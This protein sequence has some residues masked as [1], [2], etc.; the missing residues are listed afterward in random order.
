M[1]RL[2]VWSVAIATAY[3]ISACGQSG[4]LYL[5]GNPSEIQTPAAEPDEEEEK[6]TADSAEAP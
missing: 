1:K 2:L 6:K 4:P 5:P 3:L